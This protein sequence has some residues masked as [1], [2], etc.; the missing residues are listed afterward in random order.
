MF[1]RKPKYVPDSAY[2]QVRKVL[3]YTVT[4]INNLEIWRKEQR[5]LTE[6]LDSTRAKQV[7]N[8]KDALQGGQVDAEG[9]KVLQAGL[10]AEAATYKVMQKSYKN[11]CEPVQGPV[12]DYTQE[13]PASPTFAERLK[14]AATSLWKAAFPE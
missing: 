2:V 5:A 10:D 8:V 3:P 1:D 9:L 14:A 6:A 4:P 12:Y 13:T 11:A 7:Q